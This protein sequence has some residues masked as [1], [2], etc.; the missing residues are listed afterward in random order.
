MTSTTVTAH[1]STVAGDDTP[2]MHSLRTVMR[3]D[4]AVCV[5]SGAVLTAAYAPLGDL[6]G[7]APA[8]PVAAAGLFLLVLGAGLALLSRAGRRPLV[9]LVPWSAEGDFV[10][11]AGSLAIAGL[12]D[13]TGPGRAIIAA[14]AV[15]VA[16]IGVLKLR[17]VRAAR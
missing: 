16:V 15:V 14:Q 1:H 3:A 5:G 11:A 2:A 8:W 4:A 17:A 10:W 6:A 7:I 12:V 9:A 13:L